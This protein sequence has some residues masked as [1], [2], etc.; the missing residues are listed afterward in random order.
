[1]SAKTNWRTEGPRILA[2]LAV[3]V[4]KRHSVVG[5]Y[6]DAVSA[7]GL[8]APADRLRIWLNRQ[9]AWRT[10][11]R[12]VGTGSLAPTGATAPS[13]P[14]PGVVPHRTLEQYLLDKRR[15]DCPVCRLAPEV[16]AILKR[17]SEK[18]S[19]RVAEQIEWLRLDCGATIMPGEL[20]SHRSG[21]HDQ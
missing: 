2:W 21:G 1:M 19:A 17:A 5:L 11:K 6:E 16:R 9:S 20:T 10:I 13:S 14:V 15:A 3:E 18:G 12:T 4:P 8:D 7:V